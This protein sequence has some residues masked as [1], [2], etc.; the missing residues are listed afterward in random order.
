M[1][2]SVAYVDE[3]CFSFDKISLNG[4]SI[5]KCS[6]EEADIF[7]KTRIKDK[8]SFTIRVDSLK[9]WMCVGVADSTLKTRESFVNVPNCVVYY[10]DGNF[11]NGI[12]LRGKIFKKFHAGDVINV[13]VD[14]IQGK[15]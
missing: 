3:H 12:S 1:Q 14:L 10:S 8:N 4:S 11:Y 6:G 13:R 9:E 2:K 5:T 7:F 15:I